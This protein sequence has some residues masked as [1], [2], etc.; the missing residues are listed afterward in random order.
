[1]YNRWIINAAETICIGVMYGVGVHKVI[2]NRPKR[3][4]HMFCSRLEI[5]LKHCVLYLE[6]RHTFAP[7]QNLVCTHFH[8]AG[9]CIR[10][11]RAKKNLI[12]MTRYSYLGG[13]SISS[14]SHSL[15]F[16][17]SATAASPVTV[18]TPFMPTS[19]ILDHSDNAPPAKPSPR[20]TSVLPHAPL[21]PKTPRFIL[22]PFMSNY[23]HGLTPP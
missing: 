12:K 6:S 15:S 19:P 3:F 22:R 13:K 14:L 4:E 9:E 1:M 11:E 23:P 16:S 21:M 20:S 7:T 5:S 17:P 10:S 8:F 18:L 2:F